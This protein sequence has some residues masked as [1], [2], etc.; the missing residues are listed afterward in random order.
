MKLK[1]RYYFLML[2]R[3]GDVLFMNTHKNKSY[4]YLPKCYIDFSHFGVFVFLR[5]MVMGHYS[6]MVRLKLKTVIGTPLL[7]NIV[8][9]KL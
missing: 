2:M 8:T 5:L 3:K 4:L 9:I 6:I 1:A 7:G